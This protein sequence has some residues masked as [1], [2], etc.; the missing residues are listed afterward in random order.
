MNRTFFMRNASLYNC[1]CGC[2]K[3]DSIQNKN[4]YDLNKSQIICAP[5]QRNNNFLYFNYSDNEPLFHCKSYENIKMNNITNNKF[6]IK[7]KAQQIKDKTNSIFLIKKI[8]Q[9]KTKY[10]N[11]Y[12]KYS[13]YS[14][15]SIYKKGRTPHIKDINAEN[16]YLKEL[17]KG[18][19]RHEKN[20]KRIRP[21]DEKMKLLFSNGLFRMKKNDYIPIPINKNKTAK[22]IGYSSMVMPANNIN[23]L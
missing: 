13:F 14:K 18:V 9:N 1:H 17:L 2:H 6:Y 15:N 20:R 3:Y 12:N 8:N 4:L 21:S 5:I 10:G 19:P 22:F 16:S 23:K 11:S 7:E